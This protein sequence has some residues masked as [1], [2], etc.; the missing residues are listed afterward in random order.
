MEK[1]SRFTGTEM[2]QITEIKITCDW[3]GLIIKEGKHHQQ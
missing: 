3:L 1:M 2:I